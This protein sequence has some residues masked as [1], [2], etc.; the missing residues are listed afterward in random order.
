M[1][2]IDRDGDGTAEWTT[3]QLRNRPRGKDALATRPNAV[4]RFPTGALGHRLF[5]DTDDFR[6]DN[7]FS[8]KVATRANL[9]GYAGR[10]QGHCGRK[11]TRQKHEWPGC[12]GHW[13][14]RSVGLRG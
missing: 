6:S 10:R 9:P 1:A 3:R 14:S 2:L 8:A 4:W 5:F 12:P 13:M 7:G 11:I